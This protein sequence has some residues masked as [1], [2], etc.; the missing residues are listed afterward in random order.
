MD[1]QFEILAVGT[2]RRSFQTVDADRS[3]RRFHLVTLPP[4]RL[5]WGWECVTDEGQGLFLPCEMGGG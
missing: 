2:P 1:Y 5:H 3:K 4:A